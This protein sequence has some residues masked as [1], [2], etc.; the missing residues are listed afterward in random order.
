MGGSGKR[1]L[2]MAPVAFYINR[3]GWRLP[4]KLGKKPFQEQVIPG[5]EIGRMVRES[6]P[7]RQSRATNARCR[8]QSCNCVETKKSPKC[9]NS[10]F[11]PLT[12]RRPSVNISINTYSNASPWVVSLPLP[13]FA[14]GLFFH[15]GNFRYH[16]PSEPRTASTARFLGLPLFFSLARRKNQGATP[17]IHAF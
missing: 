9:E 4:E 14:Q 11:L 1:S 5:L 15:L 3:D 16:G 10:A 7:R 2:P 6:G 8:G 17:Q 12:G 13:P